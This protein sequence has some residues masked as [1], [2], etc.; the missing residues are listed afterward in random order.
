MADDDRPYLAAIPAT[1]TV[2]DRIGHLLRELHLA[3]R[4]LNLAKLADKYRDL[5][6]SAGGRPPELPARRQKSGPRRR[7]ED[8]LAEAK[9][10]SGEADP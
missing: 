1:E 5:E 8:A 7:D 6:R 2:R 9:D 10:L 4:L 3:R